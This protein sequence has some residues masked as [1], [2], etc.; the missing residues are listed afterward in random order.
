MELVTIILIAVGLAMDCFAV[1]ITTGINVRKHRVRRAVIIALCFG[2][3]QGLMPILGWLA[4]LGLKDFITGV[5]HW[6]AFGLLAF[7][8]SK[9]IYESMKLKKEKDDRNAFNGYLVLILSIATSIDALAV[10]LSFAFL[11]V[12]IIVPV[13]VI[14]GIAAAL[15]FTGFFVGQKLGHFFENRI[16]VLGGVILI[17]IGLKILIEHSIN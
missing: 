17:G 11:N 15:S 6:I 1:S 5:D 2:F 12:S 3:F 8:G 13:L 10:G 14:A 9:M 4:G 7:I 16:E